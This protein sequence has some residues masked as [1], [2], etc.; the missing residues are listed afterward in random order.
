MPIYAYR[1]EDG[2]EIEVAQGIH[3]DAHEVLQHPVTKK[4][5]AVHR[6]YGS[7]GIAFRGNG[8]YKTSNRPKESAGE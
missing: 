1:F 3:E 7:V 4:E 2:T 6:V 5:E 8:F